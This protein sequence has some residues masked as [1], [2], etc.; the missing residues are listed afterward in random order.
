MSPKRGKK[1]Q[2]AKVTALANNPAF[3]PEDEHIA[4][5]L[6]LP[7]DTIPEGGKHAAARIDPGD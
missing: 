2:L 4:E 5:E 6:F 1:Q 3:L 7:I